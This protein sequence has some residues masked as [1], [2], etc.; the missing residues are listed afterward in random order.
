MYSLSAI[1]LGKRIDI[2]IPIEEGAR[3]KLAAINFTGFDKNVVNVNALRAQFAQ[4]DGEYF[5]ATVFGKGLEALRK[6]YG[7]LGYINMVANPAPTCDEAKGPITLNIDIDPGKR[8]FVSR[9]EFTGN[10]ITRDRVIG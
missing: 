5:N 7:S 8:F 10:T 2:E 9:I 6:A 1:T 4:K 3:Y